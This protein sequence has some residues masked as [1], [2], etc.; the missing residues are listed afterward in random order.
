MPTARTQRMQKK[1]GQLT[2]ASLAARQRTIQKNP[3]QR[4]TAYSRK[5]THS[6]RGEMRQTVSITHTHTHRIIGGVKIVSKNGN[7]IGKS[8]FV[9]VTGYKTN[10]LHILD[11]FVEQRYREEG[12]LR[13]MLS[14]ITSIAK[15]NKIPQL[16]LNV[17]KGNKQA[18]QAYQ[19]FGFKLNTEKE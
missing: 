12:L 10:Y 4:T 1:K 14:E 18:K 3:L 11:V 15:Q 2:T 7:K 13:Q 9:H 17:K 6:T 5:L 8:S 16:R 19:K